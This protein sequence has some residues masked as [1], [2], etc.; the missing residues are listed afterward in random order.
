MS[1]V[2]VTCYKLYKAAVSVQSIFKVC[3]LRW[4]RCVWQGEVLS[5]LQQKMKYS[6]KDGFC[7]LVASA[8]SDPDNIVG[9]VEVS[10]QGEKVCSK[11]AKTTLAVR[12]V[13]S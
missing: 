9:V 4:C 11:I 13:V 1:V 5:G 12:W 10:L 6:H 8:A 7:C 3:V 2:A